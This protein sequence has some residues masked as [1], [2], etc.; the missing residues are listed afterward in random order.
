MPHGVVEDVRQHLPQRLGVGAHRVRAGSA[1]H[2]E[3]AAL[4]ARSLRDLRPH[5]AGQRLEGHVRRLRAP[6]AGLDAGKVQE[7]VHQLLHAPRVGQHGR[8]ELRAQLRRRVAGLQGLRVAADD[9]QRRLQL[10][11]D[12]GDEVP[13]H[14]LQALEVGDVVEHED[15]A[16]LVQRVPG[17]QDRPVPDLRVHAGAHASRERAVHHLARGARAEQLPDGRR[18]LLR[19]DAQQRARRRVH[20]RD[21]AARVTGHDPLDH[22][23]DQRRHLRALALQLG[24]AGREGLVHRL[25]GAGQLADLV[26]AA[27]VEVRVLAAG[28]RLRRVAQPHE[29]PGDVHR[30]PERQDRGAEDR[31]DGAEADGA[32]RAV[33]DLV[34]LR[35][36][37]AHARDAAREAHGDLHL[38]APGGGAEARVHADPGLERPP[39]L[40]PAG[41]VLERAELV[42]GEVGVGDDAA[43]GRDDRLAPAGGVAQGVDE[44]VE[45]G[46]AGVPDGRGGEVPRLALQLVLGRLLQPRAQ[47]PVRGHGEHDPGERDDREVRDEQPPGEAHRPFPFSSGSRRR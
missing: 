27:D 31:D 23:A 16:A 2:A 12:V 39:D 18:R 8:E 34:H 29:R 15:G 11:R 43:V 47:H 20:G 41:M 25:Q 45:R 37:R 1:R 22:R 10:V 9:G 40:G 28:D 33:H 21:R 7:V 24:E 36:R 4:A 26:A 42:G 6:A 13:P 14:R 35:Q 3:G 44:G 17:E 32:L 38:A 19:A 30:E 5:L 46:R